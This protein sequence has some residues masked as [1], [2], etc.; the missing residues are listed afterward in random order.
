MAFVQS[1]ITAQGDG[2]TVASSSSA[3]SL[4][5][6]A[7][8]LTLPPNYLNFIG[9]K[10][11]IKAQGRVSNLVTTPGTLTMDIR[12]GSTVVFNGGVMQLSTTAHTTVPW[13]ME[14]SLTVRSIGASATLMGQGFFMSQAANLA[15]ADPTTG[16]EML[17]IPNSA[18]AVGTSFDS[19]AAQVV[20][21][22]GKFSASDPL[23]SITLHQ[24]ELM[25]NVSY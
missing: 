5:P 9:V 19:T 16:H 22:F 3:T 18:P 4:L 10:L 1:L 15:G 2:A 11:T 8:K 25:S 20:D 12:F 13:W 17:L 6:A 23:N 14:I 21:L 24:Y 7:A